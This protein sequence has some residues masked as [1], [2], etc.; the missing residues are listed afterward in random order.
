MFK[1]NNKDTRTTPLAKS[2]VKKPSDY[3]KILL[4][5]PW[6][7]LVIEHKTNLLIQLNSAARDLILS[8]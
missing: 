2:Y 7:T 1:I 6:L 3:V 5:F 4:C 8:F